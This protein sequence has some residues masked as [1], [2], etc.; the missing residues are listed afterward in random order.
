MRTKD[1]SCWDFLYTLATRSPP[2][3]GIITSDSRHPPVALLA[4]LAA[5]AASSHVT[6]PRVPDSVRRGVWG[7][8]VTWRGRG[9]FEFGA[10][11]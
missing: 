5:A 10:G 2:S 6:G 3:R 9:G 7:V 4:S 8:G 1:N 11:G